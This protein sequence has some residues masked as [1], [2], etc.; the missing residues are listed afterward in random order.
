M[1][2]LEVAVRATPEGIELIADIFAEIGTGG[3][4]IEDPA[5]LARY[6]MEINPEEWAVP[7]TFLR[8]GN[9]VVKG[10][11]P[12]NQAV[13]RQLAFLFDAL[14]GFYPGE[15]PAVTVRLVQEADWANAWRAYYK[16]VRIGRRLIVKPAWESCN[17]MEEDVIIELDPGLAFGCGTHPTTVMC[18]ELLEDFVTGGETV[19]DVGTGSGILAVAAVKLGAGRVVAIDRDQLAIRVALEN[20]RRNGVE[21]LVQVVS[22]NL[23]DEVSEPVSL[24]VANITTDVIISLIPRAACLLAPGG[25]LVVSGI[26]SKRA[27]SVWGALQAVGF[28]VRARLVE[29]EWTAFV[30]EKG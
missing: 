11:L 30:C 6:A 28:T 13:E 20:V 18:L 27:E 29:G 4:V 19:Y 24:V 12:L 10:Y 1:D 22:G 23:L 21:N 25:R 26:I 7:E 8:P 16:P 9:P 3:V 15:T 5:V 2:W 14:D 17:C